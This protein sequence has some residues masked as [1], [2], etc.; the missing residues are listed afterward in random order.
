VKEFANISDRIKNLRER[1]EEATSKSGR[2]EGSVRLVAVSKNQSC[3]HIEEAL[4]AGQR[5]FGENYIAE[6]IPKVHYFQEKKSDV[7]W[8]MI[9]HLQTN[10]VKLCF[11]EGAP[12]FG[13][14]HSLD[15]LKVAREIEKSGAKASGKSLVQPVL[16]Q[17]NLVGELSKGGFSEEEFLSTLAQLEAS[18]AISLSGLMVIPPVSFTKGD[19]YHFYERARRLRDMALNQAS[20]KNRFCEISMGMSDDFEI[21]IEEGATIVRLGT[22]IFGPRQG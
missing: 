3:L 9:G 14:I 18:K 20:P 6:A 4:A 16:V 5:D 19:L 22:A 13:L 15:S 7:S 2:K 12:I 8:H 11:K 21:A 1:I 17:V 10:K